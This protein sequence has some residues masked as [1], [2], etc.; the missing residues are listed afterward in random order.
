MIFSLSEKN[1]GAVSIALDNTDIFCFFYSEKS[2][3]IPASHWLKAIAASLKMKR[4][5]LI[6]EK[7]IESAAAVLIAQRWH[8]GEHFLWLAPRALSVLLEA[9]FEVSGTYKTLKIHLAS[10]K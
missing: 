3:S 1:T 5:V 6:L 8:A 2:I 9:P 7:P 10:F 4:N